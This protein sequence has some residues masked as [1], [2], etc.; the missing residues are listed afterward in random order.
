MILIISIFLLIILNIAPRNDFLNEFSED[1]LP[2]SHVENA[3]KAHLGN[4]LVAK[5]GA[6]KFLMTPQPMKRKLNSQSKPLC[7]THII[8]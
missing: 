5:N 8:F 1:I 2:L 4:G 3:F 6:S 7:K